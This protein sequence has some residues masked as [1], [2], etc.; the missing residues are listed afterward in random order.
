MSNFILQSTIKK[1]T[2][3]KQEKLAKKANRTDK[4]AIECLA[5]H[6]YFWYN[7]LVMEMDM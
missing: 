6:I 7:Y 1:C 2:F 3:S 4:K 5:I